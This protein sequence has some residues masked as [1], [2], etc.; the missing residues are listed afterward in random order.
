M[1]RRIRGLDAEQRRE[2]RREQL[3]DAALELFARQ[4]YAGTSIEQICQAGFVGTK[5]FYEVFTGREDCYLALL[6][7]ITESLMAR[8]VSALEQAPDDEAAATRLLVAEFAHGLVDDPR[9][10]KVTF[11][12]SGA[13]SRAVEQ[14]RR[15]RRSCAAAFLEQ[16]WLRYGVRPRGV[17]AHR[18]AVGAIGGM[19]DLVADWVLDADPADPAQVEALIGDLG[20]FYRVIVAGLR[21]GAGP[22]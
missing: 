14:Q 5:A 8:M 10:A 15:A 22:V 9:L 21:G 13:M 11:G 6:R 18:M 2:Q 3:L 20:D 7:R 4:G 17:D 19:F 16:V 1:G 12:E